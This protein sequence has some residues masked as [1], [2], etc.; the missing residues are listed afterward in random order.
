MEKKLGVTGGFNVPHRYLGWSKK[1][2]RIRRGLGAQAPCSLQYHKDKIKG[3]KEKGK[4]RSQLVMEAK[5][6]KGGISVGKGVV[7]S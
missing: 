3:E 7:A 4:K 5:R 2:K 6:P 1:K